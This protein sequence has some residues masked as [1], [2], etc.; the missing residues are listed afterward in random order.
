MKL[1]KLKKGQ[2]K[3]EKDNVN[4][5]R[6]EKELNQVKNIQEILWSLAFLNFG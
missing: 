4:I 1:D 2:K 6:E 5:T 3:V